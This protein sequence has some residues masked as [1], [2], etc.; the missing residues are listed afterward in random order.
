M[1][2]V[3]ATVPSL[4]PKKPDVR[5]DIEVDRDWTRKVVT[6]DCPAFQFGK[7]KGRCKHVSIYETAMAAVEACRRQW[8]QQRADSYAGS[9]SSA[10]L[11]QQCLVDL[12]AKMAGE[13]QREKRSK[14]G[15]KKR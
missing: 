2:Q 13:L 11:C 4:D 3:V 10:G 7:E 1:A 8:L 12:L 14:K 6:C 15:A 5:Y 9:H